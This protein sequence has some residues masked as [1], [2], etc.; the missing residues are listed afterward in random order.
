M[1]KIN[2]SDF[3]IG[4]LWNSAKNDSMQSGEIDLSRLDQSLRDDIADKLKNG[5]KVRLV[6]WKNTK[7]ESGE[8]TPDFRLHAGMPDDNERSSGSSGGSSSGDSGS[9]APF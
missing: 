7:K 1:S 2:W 6:V 4:G 8:K 9:D 5:E 3:G